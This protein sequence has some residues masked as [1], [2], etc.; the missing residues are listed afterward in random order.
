MAHAKT[1]S[2]PICPIC[3]EHLEIEI[4]NTDEKCRAVH[5]DCY[6]AF[7]L[8]QSRIFAST[9][10]SLVILRAL[11]IPERPTGGRLAINAH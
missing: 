7:I 1:A 8:A 10:L 6:V 4:T 9:S 2:F 5:E 11:A 3:A